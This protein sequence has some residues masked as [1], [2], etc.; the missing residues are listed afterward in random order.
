MEENVHKIMH[1]CK[2]A[3]LDC[4]GGVEWLGNR[5]SGQGED[6]ETRRQGGGGGGVREGS[7][8]NTWLA[9]LS[10]VSTSLSSPAVLSSNSVGRVADGVVHALQVKGGR[11]ADNLY[12]VG[13][14]AS[15]ELSHKGVHHIL[16]AIALPVATNKELSV[17][18]H[19]HDLPRRLGGPKGDRGL[20]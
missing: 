5:S 11:G 13:N 2:E 4:R 18:S 7:K 10:S 14:S 17:A 3:S 20:G 9:Y 12:I 8:P 16:A 19:A 1:H 15:V 6:S